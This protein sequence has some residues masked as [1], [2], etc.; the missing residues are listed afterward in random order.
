M[1]TLLFIS[2]YHRIHPTTT[3]G[4]ILLLR[5]AALIGHFLA[6]IVK[7]ILVGSA[8]ITFLFSKRMTAYVVVSERSSNTY[9]AIVHAFIPPVLVHNNGPK[10][11]TPCELVLHDNEIRRCLLIITYLI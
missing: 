5:N 7:P 11:T 1:A 3:L 6:N 10:L 8:K 2:K 4:V 9:N